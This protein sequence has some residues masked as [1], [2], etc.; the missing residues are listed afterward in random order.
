[1]ETKS[2]ELD[3]WRIGQA[4]IHHQFD[5]GTGTQLWLF[6][7]ASARTKARV[8]EVY[9]ASKNHAANFSTT[10]QCFASSLQLHHHFASWASSEWRWFIQWLEL[11]ADELTLGPSRL[12]ENRQT[13]STKLGSLQNLARWQEKMNDVILS[14][15]SNIN[16]I[17]ELEKFYRELVK[18]DAF[19]DQDRQ[20]CLKAVQ[21]FGIQIG[22]LLGDLRI[23]TA[24]A[25]ALVKTVAERR[26]MITQ[27]LQMDAQQLQ[28]ETQQLQMRAAVEASEQ[29]NRSAQEAVAMRVVTITFFSTDI[30][31]FENGETFSLMALTRF[32]QVTLPLMALTFASAGAWLWFE[33]R[34]W[35]R[36]P[37][38]QSLNP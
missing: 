24:S 30:I 29:A 2:P 8:N 13:N 28:V 3:L 16:I 27:Q 18:D 35:R 34:N 25:E 36:T 7:D 33:R 32:L 21:A 11:V 4:T 1:M 20:A 15:M 14:M 9:P 31:K 37:A 6:G 17:G 10:A 19:P 38:A 5:L 26:A 12:T 23:Q 22:D